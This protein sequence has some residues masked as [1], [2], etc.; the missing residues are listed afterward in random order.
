MMIELEYMPV[1]IDAHRQQLRELY[2]PRA[3]PKT[4]ASRRE[5]L[6]A[7]IVRFGQWVANQCPEVA[8]ERASNSQPSLSRT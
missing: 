4:D 3:L 8:P 6:G 7:Q 1:L 5:R 2:D